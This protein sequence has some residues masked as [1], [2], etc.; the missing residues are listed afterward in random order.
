MSFATDVTLTGDAASSQT[1]SQISLENAK[2]V[3]KDAT[4][5]LGTPRSMVISHTINGAGLTAVDRHLVRLNLTEEDSGA[6]AF[7]TISGSVYCVI[8]APRRIVDATMLSDMVTQLVDFLTTSGNLDKI[9]NSE[10]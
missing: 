8:E 7:A 9:L 10:P 1:Y 6:D 2:S 3:R 4:R 5:D